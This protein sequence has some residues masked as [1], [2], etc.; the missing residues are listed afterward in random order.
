MPSGY[1]R[2]QLTSSERLFMIVKEITYKEDVVEKIEQQAVDHDKVYPYM[3]VGM[4]ENLPYKFYLVIYNYTYVFTSFSDC[5][6]HLMFSFFVFNVKYPRE[7]INVY[8]FLQHYIYGIYL[9][10]DTK[11]NAV[12]QLIASLNKK[13]LSSANNM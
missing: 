11:A 3:M 7:V 2:G 9:E 13:N 4:H 6:E 1:K 8:T 10:N 5:L 12:I